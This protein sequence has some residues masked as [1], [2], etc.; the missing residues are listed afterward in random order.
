MPFNFHYVYVLR[1]LKDGCFI[2]AIPMIYGKE[3]KII[4]LAKYIYEKSQAFGT[5]FLRSFSNKFDALKRERYFK[6]TKGK[7]VLRQ[8]LKNFLSK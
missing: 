6:T 4:T 5:Y 2:L 1:S 8:M 3:S 7:I